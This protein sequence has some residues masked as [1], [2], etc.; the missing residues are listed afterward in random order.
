MQIKLSDYVAKYLVEIGVDTVFA[1]SGGACLHLIHSIGDNPDINFVSPHHEQA[2][3]MAADG[4]ARTKNDIGVALATSGPGATN[5]ITGICCSF[6]D[7]VPVLFLT[8]QVSTF[9]MVGNT[10]VRQIGFQETPIVDICKKITKSAV[11][12]SDPNLIL[13]ELDK[14]IFK[15][16]SGRPGPVLLDIPD[17]LQRAI[18]DESKLVRFSPNRKDNVTNRISIGDNFVTKVL[19]L[20]ADSKR[21]ILIAGWGLHL[22][23]M[24]KSFIRFA[25]SLNIPI[26]LTWGGADIIPYDHPLYVGTFG[27]HGTRHANFAVQ[28]ADLVISLGSR[29]DTKSTGSPIN[30][31]ARC[32]KKIVVDI[33]AAELGKFERFNLPIDV[34][35]ND[36]LQNFFKIFLSLNLNEFQKE[37][38]DWFEKIEFWRS[39]TLRLGSSKSKVFSGVDPY[40]FI[41]Y[42]SLSLEEGSR[43][44][45]DTGCSIAWIMQGGTF[46][47]QVRVFH[48]F[49]NTAMGWALPAAIGSYFANKSGSIYCVVGDGSFM[50]TMHELG[51]LKHHKIPL[52]IFLMNNSGYGM[53]QQT[54]DQWLGSRYYA[55]S[56]KGGLSFPDYQSLAK[57]FDLEYCE[58]DATTNL[59]VELARI[60]AANHSVLCNVIIPDDARVEP[61]VKFGCPNEDMEPLLPRDLFNKCMIIPSI[62]NFTAN[63]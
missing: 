44:F 62:K 35:I 16:K 25:E 12:L 15:A 13:Y 46:S 55:S 8:G 47:S 7:S 2:A 30:S 63:E 9:R 34:L 61:Q 37:Y 41:K 45:V 19:G 43:V 38:H 14:A 50:M 26:V 24:E 4:Y 59:S 3:A 32:A 39:V 18:I 22:S 60:K 52:K 36:C 58:I 11:T 40:C 21:P 23:G 42:F 33:D 17:N 10:E 20:I 29:L 28:N 57:A 54:Q 51:T 27:T 6:Y 56:H 5:L 53:I 31:F 48:D 1:V 49:N